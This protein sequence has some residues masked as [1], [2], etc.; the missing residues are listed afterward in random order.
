MIPGEVGGDDSADAS[1]VQN[2][3]DP[4][5]DPEI[6]ECVDPTT[7]DVDAPMNPGDAAPVIPGETAPLSAPSW[8]KGH[9]LNMSG[10][11]IT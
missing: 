1:M 9:L 2:N 7:R 4:A 5:D 8:S 6:P 10:I 11:L 3:A